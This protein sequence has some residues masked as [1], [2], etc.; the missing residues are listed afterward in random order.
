MSLLKALTVVV[1]TMLLALAAIIGSGLIDPAADV[2][3]SDPVYRLL[4]LLRHRGIET[5]ARGLEVPDLSTMSMVRSGAGNY[6]AMCVDCHLKPGMSDGE[7]YRGL[8]PRP[9]AL[10]EVAAPSPAHAF[11]IIKHGIKASGMPAWGLSMDDETIWGM[12]AFLQRLPALTPTR[13]RELV[14]ESAGH[15]HGPAASDR[16]NAELRDHRQRAGPAA[17]TREV[18]RAGEHEHEHEH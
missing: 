18:S 7:L 11:W 5:R 4:E 1:L 13:Y 2:P 3:H 16:S 15:S 12:V 17:E 6:D 14:A 8:Y 9:P 10:A